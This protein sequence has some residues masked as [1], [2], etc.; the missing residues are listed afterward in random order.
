MNFI[1]YN[2]EWRDKMF[3]LFL[4]TEKARSKTLKSYEKHGYSR[5]KEGHYGSI[6][7]VKYQK[8]IGLKQPLV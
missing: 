1:P 5:F 4:E 2:A 6:P 8:Q 7:I 3:E